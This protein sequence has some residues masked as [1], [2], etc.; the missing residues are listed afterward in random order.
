MQTV[1]RQGLIIQTKNSYKS[2]NPAVVHHITAVFVF[3]FVK[4]CC[5]HFGNIPDT[6][7]IV[8]SVVTAVTDLSRLEAYVCNCLLR[9]KLL[10]CNC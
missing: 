1:A 9:H 3:D 5:V 2:E 10:M 7:I 6:S 4:N 8:K